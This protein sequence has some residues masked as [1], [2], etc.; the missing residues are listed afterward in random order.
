MDL[1]SK[2]RMTMHKSGHLMKTDRL[3]VVSAAL[4]FT[5]DYKT[6]QLERNLIHL[7]HY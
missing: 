3:N 2:L 5:D 6:D 4:I 7:K 1:I